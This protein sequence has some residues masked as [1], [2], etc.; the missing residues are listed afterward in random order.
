MS[1]RLWQ[2][3]GPVIC[4]IFL[5]VCLIGFYPNRIIYSMKNEKKDAV[6][7]T[8]TNFK[9]KYKKLRAFNDSNTQ[10]VPF[11]GSS[12]W[13]RFDAMHPS[14][15]AEAYHR[16]YTPYLL[17]QRGAASLTHFFGTQGITETF[18]KKKAIY[19]VS[20]QWFVKSG[21]NANAFQNYLTNGQIVDFLCQQKGTSYDQ[22]AAKRLLTLYPEVPFNEFLKKVSKGKRL[23]NKD[24]KQLAFQS[25]LLKKEDYFFGQFSIDFGNYAKV[26]EQVKKLPKDF[27]YSR[28]EALAIEEGEAETTN[29]EFGIRN[30]FYQTKIAGRKRQLRGSQKSFDYRISPEYQ[31]FQLM[32]HQF[33]ETE[34]NV[35]F[36]IPPVNSKWA[37]FTGLDQEMYQQTVD[38]IKYQ[39]QSQGF[40]HIAD[41]SRDG[42][43]EF[44]MQDTIHIGWKG[45]LEMD[46]N[47]N[48]FLTKESE[49]TN[50]QLNP[51]FLTEE[52]EDYIGDP[53]DFSR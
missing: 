21:T 30:E 44:F 49:K 10:F 33:A 24:I 1:R 26:L 48:P 18:K 47:V 37:A 4:A 43:K 40:T 7:L 22:Y 3:L 35:L 38:K 15:I 17:G 19:F 29:N 34:T 39:L 50:Y 51:N 6:S 31:D 16:P 12:E 11:F 53:R 27:S 42:D 28:L 25:Y 5:V 45:W 20:P 8:K 52:W 23:N 13:L 9:S 14:V 41:F 36:I 32:L 2:I 46:K